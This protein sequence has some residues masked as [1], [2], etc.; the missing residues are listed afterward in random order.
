LQENS[1]DYKRFDE[2]QNST[3]FSSESQTEAISELIEPERLVSSTLT[4][5]EEISTK[6]LLTTA[7]STK[8]NS[9][10]NR[11]S[12]TTRVPRPVRNET[13]NWKLR[14]YQDLQ[15][16]P[17]SPYHSTDFY[18]SPG[19]TSMIM[20]RDKWRNKSGCF[21]SCVQHAK[22]LQ[23]VVSKFDFTT[24]IRLCEAANVVSNIK[25]V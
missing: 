17:S 8:V 1:R 10:D 2:T 22:G 12:M 7:L 16:S 14:H 24:S 25:F 13:N 4:S 6:L 3:E 9:Y 23:T 15:H 11:F 20:M 21:H 18:S 19:P 5:G